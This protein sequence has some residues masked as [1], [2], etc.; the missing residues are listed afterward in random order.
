VRCRETGQAKFYSFYGLAIG[1][2]VLMGAFSAGNISGG[3]FNPAVAVR[4]S[5]WDRHPGR[6]SG[7]TLRLILLALRRRALSRQ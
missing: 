3:A 7:F 5:V 2:A 1:F 4:I 6:L